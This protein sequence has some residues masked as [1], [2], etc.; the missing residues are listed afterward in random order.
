MRIYIISEKH[1]IFRY[2]SKSTHLKM[3][4]ITSYNWAFGLSIK[5]KI[6]QM[7]ENNR[8]ANI[9]RAYERIE[10][11]VN[12]LDMDIGATEIHS[13]HIQSALRNRSVHHAFFPFIPLC[14]SLIANW[15]H[16]NSYMENQDIYYKKQATLLI[17]HTNLMV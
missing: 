10:T 13:Q 12:S 3:Y 5:S 8:I 2:E 16:R 17:Q 9:C 4:L 14:F 15:L 1:V 11:T 7:S 6:A